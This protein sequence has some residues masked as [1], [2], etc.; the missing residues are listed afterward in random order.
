MANSNSTLHAGASA[1]TKSP[2]RRRL[3]DN[4]LCMFNEERPP[5]VQAVGRRGRYPAIVTRLWLVPRLRQ[6]AICI[7]RSNPDTDVNHGI[8]VRL[9]EQHENG[10]WLSEAIGNRRFV[11]DGEKH[12]EV[13]VNPSVLRRTVFH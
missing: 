5:V 11:F 13:W 10:N 7:I 3:A 12:R 1:A 4:V 6:G 9:I 8:I 2:A